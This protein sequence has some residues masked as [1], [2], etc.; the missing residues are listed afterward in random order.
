[1]KFADSK[2]ILIS[3]DEN[4][5]LNQDCMEIKKMTFTELMK[6]TTEENT[7]RQQMIDWYDKQRN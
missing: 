7:V 3:F 6:D 5:L 4:R 2:E 1:M